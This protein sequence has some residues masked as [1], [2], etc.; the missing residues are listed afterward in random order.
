MTGLRT[1]LEPHARVFLDLSLGTFLALLWATANVTLWL[2][3]AYISIALGAF[4]R[5]RARS[6]ALRVGVVT[7]VGGAALLRLHSDG[8]LPADDLLEI[9]L[10]GVL[11]SLFAAFAHQRARA[12]QDIMRD[13][14]RLAQQ[15][16]RIPLA[17]DAY[18]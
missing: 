10:M 9:P 14:R 1:R 4:L 5:P 2:H 6:T 17:T 13:N 11:A 3:L 7:I 12:E 15:V 16:D 18:D 8:V